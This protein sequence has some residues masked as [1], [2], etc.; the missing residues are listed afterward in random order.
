MLS[1]HLIRT[2]ETH[3]EE[4]T[5][6]LLQDL[7]CNPRTRAF[8]GLTREQ[9]HG[10]VYDVYHN[11]GR[12]LAENDERHIESVYGELGRRRHHDHTPVSEL[13]Y[14]VILVKEH[15]RSYIRRIAAANSAIEMHQEAELNQMI[16]HF[17]DKALYYSVKG[18]EEADEPRLAAGLR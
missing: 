12:W 6:E 15:L 1:A 17:F 13:L 16:G 3:A 10:R 14:A 7:S 18:Y 9:L 4:L 8:H 11:L 2:I 5:R